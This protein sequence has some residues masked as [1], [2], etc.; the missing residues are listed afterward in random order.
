LTEEQAFLISNILA[1]NSARLLTFGEH[2]LLFFAD[3]TVAVKTGTTND[4]RDNWTIGWTPQVI[5]GVWVGNNDNSAM[6]EVASGVSGAS[7]IW[8]RLILEALS[9]Q[10]NIGFKTP[11]NVVTAEVD[12][13]SGYLAH[14]DFPSHLEYFMK[15]TQP[16]GNDSVHLKAKLCRGQER[17]ATLA[18]IARGDYE[19]KEYFVLRE[20][21][22]VSQ[23]GL[24]RWQA[25]IDTWTSQQ[26]DKRYHLPT[27]YCGNQSEL[28]VIIREPSDKQ[29]LES[30]EVKIK[31]EIVSPNDLDKVEFLVNDQVKEEDSTDQFEKIFH[32][33]Q[34]TYVLKV[35]ARDKQG[36]QSES[37]IK[38]GVQLPWDWQPSPTPTPSPVSTASP[39]ATLTST[40]TP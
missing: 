34:G 1:D 9:G 14:D 12:N 4:R 5:V 33:A 17:L 36:N 37:E 27:E 38:I 11:A 20:G 16:A 13:L 35:R 10:A 30:E 32:L 15:G 29:Q 28:A 18:Q 19:G 3:R 31:G 22:P 24:N 6:K 2:S 40:P 39:T 21:D 26:P 7:P 25:G 23:D 8:R